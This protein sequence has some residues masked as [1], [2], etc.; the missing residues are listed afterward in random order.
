MASEIITPNVII[1]TNGG[2]QSFSIVEDMLRNREVECIGEITDESFYSLCRQLRYLDRVSGEDITMFIDSPGGSVDS[3]LALYDVMQGISCKVHT[4]C[5]GTAASMAAVLFA[6][7]TGKRMIMPHGK[8]MI[9][10]PL[11]PKTGGSARYLKDISDHLMKTREHLATILARHTGHE[12]QEIYD[13]TITGDAWFD[14]DEAVAFR[15]ADCK[16]EKISDI[17]KTDRKE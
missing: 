1:E 13:K 17:Y 10:D 2:L 15:L 11:I 4:V 5:L 7:G 14:A 8:V 9:H 6:A 3:G 16:I 12:L